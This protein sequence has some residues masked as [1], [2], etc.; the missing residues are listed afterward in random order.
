MALSLCLT[1]CWPFKAAN[2]ADSNTAN[3]ANAPKI[4][5]KKG[6]FMGNL[7]A[8]FAQPSDD[9]GRRLLKEYGALYVAQGGVIR[10]G[11]VVFK[12]NEEVTAFQ[13]SVQSA[14][15]KIGPYQIELQAVAMKNLKDA[16]ADAKSKGTSITPKGADAAKR[17]YQDTVTLWASRVGPGLKSCL[18]KK[19]VTRD[20]VAR[21]QA[22]APYEQVAEVLT[23]EA[24]GCYFSKDLQ[25]SIIYSVAP[26]GSSQHLAMLAID[27]AEHENSKVRDILAKHGWFQTVQSDLPHFTFMGVSDKAL[28]KLGLKKV[29]DGGRTYWLPDIK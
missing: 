19:K 22:L 8:G 7:P 26:P 6:G 21:I 4:D 10:P 28:P 23:L 20:D 15:E 25:K 24:Q 29:T 5:I 9:A 12:D 2:K 3:S 13:A 16:V 11:V 18:G 17:S 1:G 14:R 27:V